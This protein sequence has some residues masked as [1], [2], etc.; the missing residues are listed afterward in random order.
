[1]C[2]QVIHYPMYLYAY[3]VRYDIY[4]ITHS[5]LLIVSN[6]NLQLTVIIVYYLFTN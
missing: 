6:R 4:Y 1:M 3:C 2:T 5:I